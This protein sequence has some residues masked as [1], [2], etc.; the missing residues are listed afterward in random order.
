M[1]RKAKLNSLRSARSISGRSNLP[2]SRLT[3][4]KCR[5]HKKPPPDPLQHAK[6]ATEDPMD[7][8][9]P[10]NGSGPGPTVSSPPLTRVWADRANRHG[11]ED[12]DLVPEPD[13]PQLSEDEEE[14]EDEGRGDVEEP[15]FLT[16]DE[17]T[18]GSAEGTLVHVEISTRDQLN[19]DFQLHAARAGV[20]LNTAASR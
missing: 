9:L 17:R 14:A 1:Q 18:S 12:E 19:A 16:D 6:D 15:E 20:F 2:A 11:R 13:S 5:S 8:D 7:V 3:L 4:L 10:E